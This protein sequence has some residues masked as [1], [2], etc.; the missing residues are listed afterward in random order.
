[1]QWNR[2][3]VPVYSALLAPPVLSTILVLRHHILEQIVSV[4]FQLSLLSV[5]CFFHLLSIDVHLQLSLQYRW[6][7]GWVDKAQ[8]F[9]SARRFGAVGLR[10]DFSRVF[11]WPVLLDLCLENFFP[12]NA[13]APMPTVLLSVYK[14]SI[15]KLLQ[16]FLYLVW[17]TKRD[18]SP[19][20]KTLKFSGLFP[21]L[22]DGFLF[23][24]LRCF[25]WAGTVVTSEANRLDL[26]SF[27]LLLTLLKSP[28][29]VLACI[30]LTNE[31]RFNIFLCVAWNG[32]FSV[33]TS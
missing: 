32:D 2:E 31:K 11:S 33:S 18:C 27:T 10:P 25:R 13:V 12:C 5:L 23:F 6:G 1:M 22:F 8:C 14:M 28:F 16:H 7:F 30:S 9:R 3:V 19:K 20:S 15:M 29:S 4:S 24:F 26:K 17:F 21:L